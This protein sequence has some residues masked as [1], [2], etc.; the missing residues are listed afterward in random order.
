MLKKRLRKPEMRKILPHS[1]TRINF[2][3][4]AVL[5]PQISSTQTN[6]RAGKWN[7][8]NGKNQTNLLLPLKILPMPAN[9]NKDSNLRQMSYR[10]WS[11]LKHI[12]TIQNFSK[13]FKDGSTK[14]T[15]WNKINF[16]AII[17]A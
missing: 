4:P 8:L 15:H 14:Q 11:Y 12:K 9:K 5:S 2:W 1:A 10:S 16:T 17:S 3:K 7:I 13:N 6:W